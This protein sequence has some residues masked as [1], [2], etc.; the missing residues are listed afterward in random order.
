[1]EKNEVMAVAAWGELKDEK[2]VKWR[3]SAK[4]LMIYQ[5]ALLLQSIFLMQSS[6][7]PR[8]LAL[9]AKYSAL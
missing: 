1:M 5:I 7:K 9:N 2:M 4:A 3:L 6:I 8:E